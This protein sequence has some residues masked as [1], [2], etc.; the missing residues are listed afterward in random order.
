M[1]PLSPAAFTLMRAAD[2]LEKRGW[3]K[4]SYGLGDGPS[5]AAGAIMKVVRFGSGETN[6]AID[7]LRKHLGVPAH[8]W[9]LPKWNDQPGQTKKKVIAAMRAAAMSDATVR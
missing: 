3:I 5:C 1:K 4:H 9:S 8:L 2:L 7:L 6:G